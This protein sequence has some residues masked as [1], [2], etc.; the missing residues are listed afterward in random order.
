MIYASIER[1]IKNSIQTTK[2]VRP[3]L[4]VV[5]K[6]LYT[7]TNFSICTLCTLASFN[8]KTNRYERMRER[9]REKYWGR[10]KLLHTLLQWIAGITYQRKENRSK[11]K[12]L[13]ERIKKNQGAEQI[14]E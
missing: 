8:G 2:R 4:S 3:M 9:E 6:K 7:Q 11:W 5:N 13:L 1:R 14:S 10:S 12:I